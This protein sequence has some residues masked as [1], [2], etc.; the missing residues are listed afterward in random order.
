MYVCMYVCMHIYIYIYVWIYIYIYIY[1][2]I[3]LCIWGIAAL[4]RRPRVSRLRL[5][6]VNNLGLPYCAR[7]EL[8]CGR[9]TGVCE[10]STPPEK[11][12]HRNTSFQST[13]SGAGEQFLLLH[14]RARACAKGFVFLQTPVGVSSEKQQGACRRTPAR[15]YHY[16][17]FCF[18]YY[19]CYY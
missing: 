16:Y 14:C 18:K 1:I 8:S 12:T 6:A 5:E 11:S 15:T 7:E 9:N 2:H 19:Y 13:K 10:K 17:Y 4:L 3:H